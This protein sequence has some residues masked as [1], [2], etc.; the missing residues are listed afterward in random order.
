LETIDIKINLPAT[1][2]TASLYNA[3]ISPRAAKA[4]QIMG[5]A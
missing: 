3:T 2:G 5:L 1:L 4:R